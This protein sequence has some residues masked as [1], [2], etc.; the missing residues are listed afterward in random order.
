MF[1]VIGH[2][3]NC[4]WE[5]RKKEM[6][7]FSINKRKL[8]TR[9]LILRL[10][11][12]TVLYKTSNIFTYFWF[13]IKKN[14]VTIRI[15]KP[16]TQINTLIIDDEADAGLL[17]QN[18][19]DDFSAIIIKQVFTDALKALDAVILEQPEVI[20]LDVEMPE[21]TGI[22]FLKQLNKFAPHTKV[23]FVTAYKQYALEAIQN[24]AFDFITKPIAKD[25]LRRVA[26]KIVATIKKERKE[27]AQETNQRILLKTIEGHHYV[28]VDSVLYLEADGN[29]TNLIL[30]DG[31]KLLSSVNLGRI[32]EEFPKELF[33]RISRKHV[34]NK[35]YLTF[36]N[37]CKRYC[38]VS[39]N[40]NEHK[41]DVSVKLKDLRAELG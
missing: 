34:V 13:M 35:N 14:D 29:Y 1:F 15:K 10:T 27:T 11:I 2:W 36:M 25:E 31:K 39:N 18:L 24:E 23:V 19:L 26:H 37:F 4:Q 3:D 12:S 32:I 5:E 33:V 20:F 7:Q 38:I 30:K 21:I 9:K 8:D 6:L 16:M 41:L 22:E 17:L 40:G 28:S